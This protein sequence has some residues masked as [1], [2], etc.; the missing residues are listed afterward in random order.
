MSPSDL[1]GFRKKDVQYFQNDFSRVSDLLGW[2]IRTMGRNVHTDMLR[3]QSNFLY[4]S[5][6][7]YLLPL[8][9]NHFA[10]DRRARFRIEYV[11][12]KN[13]ASSRFVRVILARR[14]LS[15]DL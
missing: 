15:T 3:L 5:S 6:L 8:Y 14:N 10:D 13:A 11:G 2:K 12:M 9:N 4:I 1:R 7:Y